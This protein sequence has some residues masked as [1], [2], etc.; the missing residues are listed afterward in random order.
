MS[1]EQIQTERFVLPAPVSCETVSDGLSPR[2]AR[3]SGK[4]VRGAQLFE[5]ARQAAEW[6][7][8]APVYLHPC[9][10]GN[11][12][13]LTMLLLTHDAKT[14]TC[15]VCAEPLHLD[16]AVAH[17]DPVE[18][19]IDLRDALTRSALTCLECDRLLHGPTID[20][21]RRRLRRRLRPACPQCGLRSL[22]P[23]V[24]DD[25]TVVA[26]S[27]KLPVDHRW[28]DTALETTPDPQW[29]CRACGSDVT[30]SATG[31]WQD[32]LFTPETLRRSD[33]RPLYTPVEIARALDCEPTRSS[34]CGALTQYADRDVDIR[35]VDEYGFTIVAPA[36]TGSQIMH[37]DY[38]VT[39][40]E[41]HQIIDHLSAEAVER[42]T[43]PFGDGD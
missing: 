28:H 11:P 15:D 5:R 16:D 3:R 25:E 17:L 40:S 12:V 30:V 19:Y 39:V 29:H 6:S 9:S 37:V 32:P 43:G 36:W 8:P 26:N 27:P 20:D 4:P 13:L 42:D 1:G 14:L 10:W 31:G 21:L 23:I 24:W 18:P 41:L 35:D 2:P 34:I 7:A 33:S 22:V 38:P